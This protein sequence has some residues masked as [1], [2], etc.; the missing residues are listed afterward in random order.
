MQCAFYHHIGIISNINLNDI[1]SKN[2][3]QDQASVLFLMV[4]VADTFAELEV[5]I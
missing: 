1:Q 5:D 3:S 4:V 2:D